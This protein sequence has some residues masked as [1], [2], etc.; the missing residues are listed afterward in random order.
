VLDEV[1]RQVSTASGYKINSGDSLFDNGNWG[2][3]LNH[4]KEYGADFRP[5][6]DVL[7]ELLGH[8][9]LWELCYVPGDSEGHRFCI[10]SMDVRRGQPSALALAPPSIPGG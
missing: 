10:F 5:A 1:I 8:D 2:P 6:R 3:L 7:A 4:Q 9:L